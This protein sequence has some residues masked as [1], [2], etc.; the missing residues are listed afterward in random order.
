MNHLIFFGN[1]VLLCVNCTQAAFTIST[2]ISV[3]SFRQM[4]LVF[5][6]VPKTGTGLSC[7]IYNIP[8][9]FSLSLDMKPGTSNPDKCYRKFR[10][11]R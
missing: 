11:F 7:T 10:S 6:L 5:F 3:K 4:L 1:F 8:V 2:E 9:N